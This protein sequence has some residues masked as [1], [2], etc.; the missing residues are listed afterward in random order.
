MVETLKTGTA[1]IKITVT[2]DRLIGTDFEETG[3]INN[4][5]EIEVVKQPKNTN[6]TKVMLWIAFGLLLAGLI[7]LAVKAIID[8]RKIE[9]K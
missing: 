9:V 4:E 6:T 3:I 8:A 7:Y 5:F 1:G 2:D